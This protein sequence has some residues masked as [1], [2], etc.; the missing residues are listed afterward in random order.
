MS[1]ASWP[2]ACCPTVA[3]YKSSYSTNGWDSHEVSFENP[4]DETVIIAKAFPD[5]ADIQPVD[6]ERD[7]TGG[8]GQYT[9][10]FTQRWPRRMEPR[11]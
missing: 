8:P 7:F 6:M 1:S 9:F 11:A 4:E 3:P 10:L 5:Y 2:P